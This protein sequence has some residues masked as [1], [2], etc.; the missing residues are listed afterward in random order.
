MAVEFTNWLRHFCVHSNI[1]DTKPSKII[2]LII[3]KIYQN[4]VE[5]KL[6]KEIQL[7]RYLRM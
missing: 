6:N 1:L 3:V 2:F 4:L 7:G 5:I